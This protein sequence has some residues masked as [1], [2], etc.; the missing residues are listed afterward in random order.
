MQELV[1]VETA[2][3]RAKDVIRAACIVGE[4]REDV[5]LSHGRVDHVAHVRKVAVAVAREVTG[6]S[7]I[8]LGKAFRRDHSSIVHSLAR[9]REDQEGCAELFGRIKETA[10]GIAAGKVRTDNFVVRDWKPVRDRSARNAVPD[11]ADAQA[12]TQVRWR[13]LTEAQGQ[14]M[15]RLRRIG[16]S[17]KGLAKRYEIT[18]SEIRSELGEP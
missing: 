1:A 10:L 9:V 3:V 16:W 17:T 11:V 18:E 6:L 4:V 5:F 2:R 14:E 15:L 12:P 7:V 13:K 8:Q